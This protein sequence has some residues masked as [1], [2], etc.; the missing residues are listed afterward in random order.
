[1][2]NKYKV[3][4]LFILILSIGLRIGF[5][6]VNRQANDP[7]D[8]V[9][10]YIIEN[11]S[12]PEKDDCWECFQPKLFHFTTAMILQIP[13]LEE[14]RND[15]SDLAL[16]VEIINLIASMGIL[17]VIALLIHQI[18][19]QNDH[20]KLLAFGLAALNPKLIGINAQFT[21]D[22]FAILFSSLALYFA[23]RYLK[24]PKLNSFLFMLFFVVLGISTEATVWVIAIVIFMALMVK[25]WT[26]R[27][28]LRHSFLIALLFVFSTLLI[29]TINPLNQY[30][31]N[32]E[33]H[34]KPILLNMEPKEFPNYFHKTEV[35]RPG[36]LSIYDGF[37]SF[38][39]ADLLKHP[40]NDHGEEYTV[41]RT[42]LW[43][44]LY[45]RMHSIHF[46]NYPDT[47]TTKGENGFNL[48]RAIFLLALLPTALILF[49]FVLEI[50][51]LL[52]SIIKRVEALSAQQYDG[53]STISAFGYVCFI[54]LYT[55]L[56]R[57]FT[58]MKPVFMY[59]SIIFLPLFFIRGVDF[60]KSWLGDQE[61]WLKITFT[62]WMSILLALYAADVISMIQLIVSHSI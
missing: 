41:T 50:L 60:F 21:N 14:A 58:V 59:P 47:W 52:K 8:E 51:R 16:Q 33:V 23:I 36:I 27:E 35:G 20:L 19:V 3:L 57:D 25:A 5:V 18:P 56:Y 45:A 61:K 42:S 46:N 1:M 4:F 62:V 26:H 2:S 43:T 15:Q 29:S 44:M 9:I 34:G 54:I 11:G 53:L 24:M 32:I 31:H 40:I 10:S 37:L 30:I 7:H 13:V 22:T 55:L 39:F 48:S 49:G 28:N 17:I 38:R 6:S 12:L